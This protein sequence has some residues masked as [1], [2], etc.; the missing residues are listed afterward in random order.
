VRQAAFAAMEAKRIK[1]DS[2]PA[3]AAAAATKGRIIG[4]STWAPV[5]E[6]L[7]L[8]PSPRPK[9]LEQIKLQQFRCADCG[10]QISASKIKTFNY[11][12][13][14][15]KYFCRCCH[16]NSRSYIPAYVVNLLDFRTTF[17]VSKK[18]KNFLDRIYSEPL[19][20][21]DSLN[22]RL[23][24]DTSDLFPRI[25][26]LRF[27]LVNSR[28]YLN[29]CRFAKDLK[30]RLFSEYDDFIINDQHVYSIETL[31]KIKKTGNY[32]EKLRDIVNSIV[33]HIKTCELCSQQGYICGMCHR[34]DLLYPFELEKVTNFYFYKFF[35]FLI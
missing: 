32:Y 12:E 14:F 10:I 18:A 17:E 31:F 25:K 33:I 6:Q 1:D 26:K 5:R 30:T 21:L 28:S 11:C 4:D 20:T 23:F 22:P 27:K 8:N 24:Q 29:S 7:I 13:Y 16:I 34:S 15:S 19:I 2:S 9:R 35:Y 3:A